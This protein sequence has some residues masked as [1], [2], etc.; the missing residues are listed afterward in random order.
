MTLRRF[1][2]ATFALLFAVAVPAAAQ[3]ST[4]T[5][6]GT[7][8]DESK[9][10]LPGVTVTAIESDTGRRYVATTDESG[11]FHLANMA[12]GRYRVQAELT[13]FATTELQELELNCT[14]RHVEA[15]KE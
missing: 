2:F 8:T 13:G 10:V 7:V 9:G 4:A 3:V 12:P 6:N 14:V 15:D 11:E 1:G 5:L